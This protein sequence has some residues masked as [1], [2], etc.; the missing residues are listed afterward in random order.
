MKTDVRREKELEIKKTILI[1]EDDEINGDILSSFLEND[2][3]ILRAFNGKECLDILKRDDRIIDMV[4]LDIFMPVMNGYQV[5]QERQKNPKLKRIPFIVMTSETEIEKECFHLGV[6]DFIKKPYDNPDIIVARINRMIEL[7]EDR[8]II[9]EVKR[10]KLTNLYS[11]EFF[12]KYCAQF[13]LRHPKVK[14]D[15]L[16][17]N[18]TR[19]HLINE[20]YGHDFADEI[21]K[22]IGE[23]IKNFVRDHEGIAARANGDNFYIYCYHREDY[24]EFFNAIIE[25]ATG[26][27]HINIVH[28]RVG[29]YPNVK[30]DMDIDIVIGRAMGASLAVKEDVNRIF[31][32]YDVSSE[33]KT[34]YNEHLINSFD[35]SLKNKDFKIYFQPKYKIQGEKNVLGSAEAL[36]RWVHPEYGMVSPGVFVPLFEKNGLIQRLDNYVLNEVA[37]KM[38]EW[39][40]KYDVYLPV[41]INISRVDIYN[42]NLEEEILEAFDSR[43]IP[44][45]YC[46]IEITES[47]YSTGED[48]II[49]LCS[50]L[51]EKGFVIE[52][53]DFG[54]GYSTLNSLLDIPFDV[55]KIDMSFIRKLDQNPK[56]ANIVQMIINICKDIGVV[57][58]AEG[59]ETERHYSFLKEAG[60]DV[61]QGYYFSKPLPA[62]EFEELF[63]KELGK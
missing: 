61:I 20:L 16:A 45:E 54:T 37:E 35:E 5:L 18:I 46:Y 63:K 2:F 55:L 60:C 36:V 34:H 13:N 33:E 17:I 12:K 40:N 49:K 38:M 25:H 39:K 62:S 58:V 26:L 59:V 32:V 21:L 15:L 31:A 6:N 50:S 42:T 52:I 9:K 57:S 1:V 29:I 43:N 27:T 41:S 7:Y 3:Y 56:N 30:A 10:D 4:L 24:S 11:I 22:D 8:S 44:H 28:I 51:K 48:T 19:F 53:D 47:A 23:S 14:K